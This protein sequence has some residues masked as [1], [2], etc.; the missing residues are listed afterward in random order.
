MVD[1]V[2]SNKEE[3]EEEEAT[4][5]NTNHRSIATI[6]ECIVRL[7]VN[8]DGTTTMVVASMVKFVSSLIEFVLAPFKIY[9]NTALLSG[10]RSI[11]RFNNSNL[12]RLDQLTFSSGRALSYSCGEI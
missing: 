12:N 6:G 5:K 4:T 3:E 8:Q 1:S 10:L 7:P 9:S 11:D 2:R